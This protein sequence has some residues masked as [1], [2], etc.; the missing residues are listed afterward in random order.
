MASR[1]RARTQTAKSNARNVV[2]AVESCYT[3]TQDYGQCLTAAQMTA[4]GSKPGV[5]IGA[6][7]GE[8]SV[9]SAS[10]AEYA[11]TAQSRNSGNTFTIT[12]AADGT[13]SR[14]CSDPSDG[15]CKAGGVW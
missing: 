9:T 10:A 4:A 13:S 15:G 7:V 5:T 6:G 14:T 12:K 3:D 1:R 8:V 11:V 2:S